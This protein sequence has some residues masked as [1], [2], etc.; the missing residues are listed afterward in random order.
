MTEQ[1]SPDGI[2]LADTITKLGSDAAGAVVVSGSHGGRYA[3]YLALKAGPCGFILNDAGG[4]KDMAGIGSL[5]WAQ[6]LGVAAATVSHESCRI[7]QAADMMVRG[8]ISHAN[9]VAQNLGVQVDMAC[10]LAAEHMRSGGVSTVSIDPM[11]ETRHELHEP[12][13]PRKIVLIDSASLVQAEDAGQIIVCGSHG[14]LVGSDPKMALRVDGFAA[15]FH[16]AGIGAEGCGITRLPALDQRGI[17]GLTVAGNSARIGDGRSMFE[18]G[19]ISHANAT[20]GKHGIKPGDSAR[21]AVI[22]LAQVN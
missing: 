22:A 18:D 19:V 16:D 12:G 7:G 17:V 2:V 1:T 20:A 3:G 9:T 8:T 13:W 6:E 4:G 21:D 5:T 10:R 15:V 14:G 11:N